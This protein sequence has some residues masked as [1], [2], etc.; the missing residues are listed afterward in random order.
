MKNK[1]SVVFFTF[2]RAII[3]HSALTSLIKCSGHIIEYPIN[4][5]YH[6]DKDH[7]ASYRLLKKRFKNKIIIHERKKQ[8]F[9]K[10]FLLLLRP[11]NLLWALRYPWMLKNYTNFK[12]LLEKILL[13]NKSN[14][15]MLCTDDT[16]FYRKVSITKKIFNL[17]EHLKEKVFFRT[18]FGL[19]LKGIHYARKQSYESL[20]NSRSK[21]IIWNSKNKNCNY[22]MKYHF[23]V[24]GAVYD[25]LSLLR[26]L[27]PIFY[28][29]PVTLEAIGFRE[30][31]LRGYFYNTISEKKRSAVTYEI[32]S[33]QKDTNLRFNYRMQLNPVLLMKAY[34][35]NYILYNLIPF[36]QQ[37]LSNIVP[38]V[39][40]VIKNKNKNKNKYKNI[41]KLNL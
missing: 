37:D 27:K 17:I 30:A 26:F 40:Y 2:K 12:D 18:N 5:I 14:L 35:N 10:I 15:V 1:V 25:R 39:V 22:H 31:K 9:I 33:V 11:L 7:D 28:H 16:I 32:N 19:N 34:L 3:L 6:Y 24:E 29:N 8:S 21:Y 20:E 38:K 13:E 36:K 41:L 4:I 23:Q